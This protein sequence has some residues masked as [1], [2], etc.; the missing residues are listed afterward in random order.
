MRTIGTIL[1]TIT[2]L[3]IGLGVGIIVLAWSGGAPAVSVGT[4]HL[5]SWFEVYTPT[6]AVFFL[7]LAMICG[8]IYAAILDVRI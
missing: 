8:L 1:E 6:I 5:R 2:G 4:T 7:F 3:F